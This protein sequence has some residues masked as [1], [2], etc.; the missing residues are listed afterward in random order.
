MV[1]TLP[2]LLSTLL[3]AV[4]G[5]V[6]FVIGFIVL[7]ILTPGKLWE[8]INQ[9]QNMAVALFSGLVALGFAII[10]AASIHG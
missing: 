10:V 6:M 2:A 8:E 3:Y 5:I 1:T 4:I 9:K 7:D